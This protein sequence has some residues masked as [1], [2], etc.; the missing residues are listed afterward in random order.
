[1][2][3]SILT[4]LLVMMLAFTLLFV[5][6]HLVAMRTEILR[7]RAETLSGRPPQRRDRLMD[8][9][10]RRTPSSSSGPMPASPSV[11]LA[12]IGSAWCDARR[13]KA[14]LAALE[15]QGIRRR[16]A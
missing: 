1:M 5:L 11:T 16:S 12:L 8:L 14:R 15:A 6:L 3:P 10:T 2:P 9:G 7:R 4:P 13:V